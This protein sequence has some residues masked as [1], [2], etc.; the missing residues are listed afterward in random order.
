MPNI[1]NCAN[2]RKYISQLE[3]EIIHKDFALSEFRIKEFLARIP[4]THIYKNMIM[5]N[6]FYEPPSEP[7]PRIC[8]SCGS[9]CYEESSHYECSDCG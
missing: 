2:C 5:D 1:S 4:H 8:P 7:L 9:D 3:T 6:S